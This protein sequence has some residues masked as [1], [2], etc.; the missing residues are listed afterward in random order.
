MTTH[1]SVQR[2]ETLPIHA[3]TTL[4]ALANAYA[5]ATRVFHRHHLDFCCGG[6]AS[7]RDA[8]A[9]KGLDLALVLDEL[10]AEVG[11]VGRDED[12]RQQPLPKL[13]EHIVRHFHAAHRAELPRLLAMAQKVESVHAPNRDCPRGLADHLS[14]VQ[15]EMDLHMQKEEQILFPALVAGRGAQ[16]AAPIHCMEQEHV[17]HG[18]NLQRLTAADA[19]ALGNELL[20]LLDAIEAVTSRAKA[21]D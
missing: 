9:R 11:E 12:W 4:A 21:V 19:Q 1:G 6:Q 17:Q 15:Q 16:A 8:C 18:E 3:D 2:R 10:R 13:V 14:F 5:G 20:A 7:L